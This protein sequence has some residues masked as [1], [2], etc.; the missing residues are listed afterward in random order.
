MCLGIPRWKDDFDEAIAMAHGFD[1]VTSVVPVM[2][3]Y[4]F[5]ILNGA[6]LSNAAALRETGEAV[7]IAERSGDDL[8]LLFARFARGTALVHQGGPDRGVGFDLLAKVRATSLQERFSLGMVPVVDVQVAREKARTGD[9]DGA[10]ELL[11][12]AIDDL[13]ASGEMIT[14]GSATTVLVESLLRRGD[15]ADV[16]EAQAAIER[17]AAVPTDP[18]F[19]LND[20]W[21]LRLRALLARAHGDESSYREYRDRYRALA[22]SLGFEGHMKWSEAMP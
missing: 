13:F 14:P 8:A 2:Y 20:I 5:S 21:L 1:P 3:K 15:D 4:L 16:Q 12:E 7:A 19:V 10:I 9:L 18:G 22:T 11:R 6:L 17:L